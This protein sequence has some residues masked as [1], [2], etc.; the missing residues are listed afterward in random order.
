MGKDCWT[1]GEGSLG[2]VFTNLSGY[3][4]QCWLRWFGYVLSGLPDASVCRCKTMVSECVKRGRGG[5]KIT[6]KKVVLENLQ[7]LGIYAD[8]VKGRQER[9]RSI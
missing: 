2:V 6:W 4:C 7:S 1:L 8:L 9:K 3:K 5:R